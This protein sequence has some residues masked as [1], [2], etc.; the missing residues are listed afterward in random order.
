MPSREQRLLVWSAVV[1]SAIVLAAALLGFEQLLAFSVPLLV[2]GMP[3]LAGRYLG[4]KHLTRLASRRS[5][6]RERPAVVRVPLAWLRGRQTAVRGGRLIAVSLAV[7]PP[8]APA[9]R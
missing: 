5:R 7:R 1:S 6:R 3:L 2:L 9:V 8:P 4:E